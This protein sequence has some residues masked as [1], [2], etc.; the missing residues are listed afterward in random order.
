LDASIPGWTRFPAAEEWLKKWRTGQAESQ[1]ADLK[2]SG[3]MAKQPIDQLFRQFM[4]WRSQ[5]K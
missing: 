3:Q 1:E 2:A 5:G 4:I